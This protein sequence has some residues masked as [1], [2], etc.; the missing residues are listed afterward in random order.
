MNG[1]ELA[2]KSP[3]SESGSLGLDLCE[4]EPVKICS[5]ISSC[6]LSTFRRAPDS[7]EGSSDGRPIPMREA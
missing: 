4:D 3:C 1:S 2:W 6:R 7:D 5:Q